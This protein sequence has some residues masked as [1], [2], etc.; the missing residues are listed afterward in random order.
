MSLILVTGGVRSGKS[1][2][3]EELARQQGG[4]VL[5]QAT[6]LA[7][8]QEMESRIALHRDRRPAGWGLL[9]SPLELPLAAYAGYDTVL[10]DCLSAWISNHLFFAEDEN[11]GEVESAVLD[12]LREW[13]DRVIAGTQT[14]IVVSSEVGM[15]GVAM[16]PLGRS[17]QD[18]LGIANQMIALQADEVHAVLSGI[19]LRLK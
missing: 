8:D 4:Q 10:I 7:S 11:Y 6:G 16:S 5:Y 9:E 1:E 19:P 15:G 13:I 17:F 2:F 12:R 14:V 3:A 18:V